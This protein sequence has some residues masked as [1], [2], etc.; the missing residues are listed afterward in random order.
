MTSAKLWIILYEDD[1]K[2]FPG[3]N[4]ITDT[5]KAKGAKVPEAVWDAT[6]SPAEFTEDVNKMLASNANTKYIHFRKGT[7]IPSGESAT[8]DG[9]NRNTWRVAYTIEGVR[10][11]YLCR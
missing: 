6:A 1:E 7:V 4:A 3:M 5:L 8:R 11:C 10:D 2:A 9:G